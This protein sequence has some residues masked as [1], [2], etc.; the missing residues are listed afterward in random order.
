MHR[1]V[2]RAGALDLVAPILGHPCF[3]SAP[4]APHRIV[5]MQRYLETTTAGVGEMLELLKV[6]ERQAGGLDR[7][8]S[9]F[10][11]VASIGHQRHWQGDCCDTDATP[12]PLWARRTQLPRVMMRAAFRECHTAGCARNSQDA[13]RWLSTGKRFHYAGGRPHPAFGAQRPGIVAGAAWRRHPDTRPRAGFM[14]R[15]CERK[16]ASDPVRASLCRNRPPTSDPQ[17][18]PS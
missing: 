12:L 16:L 10:L 5:L 18:S 8:I 6:G 9:M 11:A 14:R 7:V 2:F 17:T 15:N 1:G 13:A 4:T 3:R